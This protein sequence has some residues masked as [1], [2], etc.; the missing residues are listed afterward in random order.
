MPF[1]SKQDIYGACVPNRNDFLGVP[2]Q[3]GVSKIFT[4]SQAELNLVSDWWEGN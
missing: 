1:N 4:F 2:Q 3:S